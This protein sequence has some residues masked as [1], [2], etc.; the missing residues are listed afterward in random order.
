MSKA[1]VYKTSKK[2]GEIYY[3]SSFT[4]RNKH[5]S[6]G[7]FPKEA[8]ANRAYREAKKLADSSL[9]I[10]DYQEE[11]YKLPF[12]KYVSIVNF[13][14]NGVYFANPIYLR[15]RYFEYYFSKTLCY[16]FDIDD[17]FYFAGHKISR[18][19]NHLFVADYGMQVNFLHRYGIKSHAV[20][21]R[22]YRFINGDP[23]DFR[24]ENIEIINPYYGVQMIRKDGDVRYKSTILING[25]YVIGYY[26][27]PELAA[28]AYNKAVDRLSK[29]P[30]HREYRQN[31][32]ESLTPREYADL[33]GQIRISNRLP[34]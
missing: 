4:F 34:K 13:R 32:I 27:T 10:L 5:I 17:L 8:Q 26:D 33:Y 20:A 23:T 25:T 30:G 7:S 11:K 15:K 22:D 28:I 31:Y 24:Y 18:R 12:E 16:K 1:G 9:T 29:R 2:N 19:G 6:L 21:D 14:D 3:R